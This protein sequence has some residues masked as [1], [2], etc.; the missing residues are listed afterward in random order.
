M[1]AKLTRE[2][3]NRLENAWVEVL[4]L[5]RYDISMQLQQDNNLDPRATQLRK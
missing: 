3:S 2:D 4:I 5:F 1:A